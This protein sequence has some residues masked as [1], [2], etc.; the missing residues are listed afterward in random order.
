MP[1]FI[2][3]PPWIKP[4]K[5]LLPDEEMLISNKWESFIGGTRIVLSAKTQQRTSHSVLDY[6][7]RK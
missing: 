6:F 1:V 7:L 2:L 3:F 4:L 5:Y